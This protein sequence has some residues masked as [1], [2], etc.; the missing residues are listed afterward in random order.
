ME[1][2]VAVHVVGADD[3]GAAEPGDSLGLA[4]EALD[5]AGFF[6]WAAGSTLMATGRCIMLWEHRYTA[7]MPPAPSGSRM[8]YLPQR[9]KLRQRPRSS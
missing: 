1:L 3:V 6:P 4:V 8:V 5:G 9:M 7:P 2:A